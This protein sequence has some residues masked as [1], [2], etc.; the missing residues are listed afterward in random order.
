VN[1]FAAELTES[2]FK[3]PT[4][5]MEVKSDVADAYVVADILA[6]E[7]DCSFY[8]TYSRVLGWG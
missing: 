1:G 4:R 7:L 8:E 3:Q 2:E 6:D 5:N